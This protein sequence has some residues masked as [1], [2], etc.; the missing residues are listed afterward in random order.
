MDPIPHTQHRPIC[1]S[2]HLVI[3]QQHIPF[4]RRFN[5]LKA[6]WN[7]YSAELDKLIEDI[8]PILAN[9]KCFV[10]SVRVASIRHIARGC[11]TEYIPCL[12]DE[13]NSLYEDSKSKYAGFLFDNGTME[14]E[15]TLID[16]MRQEKGRHGRK[17]LRHQYDSQLL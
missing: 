12:T 3:V 4:R 10:E 1:V 16:R 11:R 5:H 13:S 17:S 8:E 7:G 15:S 2:V 6:D 9:D 14:S